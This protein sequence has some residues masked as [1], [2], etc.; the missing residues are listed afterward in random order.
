MYSTAYLSTADWNDTKFNNAEFDAT[1]IAARAELD[2]VK[3]KEEYS[4]LANTVRDEGGLILPMFNDFVE[5]RREEVGGWI[6][7]PNGDLMNGKAL[8][9]CW[10]NA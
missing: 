4:E 8:I 5:A 2:P 7:D 10:V 9:K 6:V 1:L 3:R